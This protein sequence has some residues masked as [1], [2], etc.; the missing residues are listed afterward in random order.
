MK[1]VIL[2]YNIIQTSGGK[3][4]TKI[5]V[6][7]LIPVVLSFVFSVPV[8]HS[9]NVLKSSRPLAFE[10]D[11]L[12]D[13]CGYFVEGVRKLFETHVSEDMIAEAAIKICE[14][15]EI[16]DKY[17]CSKIVPEFKVRY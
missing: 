2:L 11:V 14:M 1:G 12:C 10:V 13:M 8:F 3:G 6:L 5:R 9:R 17:I 7:F 15:L 16:E 4:M